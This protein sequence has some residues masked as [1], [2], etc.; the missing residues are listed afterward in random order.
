MRGRAR[1]GDQEIGANAGTLAK[2]LG[3]LKIKTRVRSAILK[4][5]EPVKSEP[6]KAA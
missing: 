1:G 6:S 4:A 5:L 3:G 2:A